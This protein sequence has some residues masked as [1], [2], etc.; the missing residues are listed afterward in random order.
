[1]HNISNGAFP[2]WLLSASAAALL[3]LV[4]G[5]TWFYHSQSRQYHQMA[6]AELMSIARLK[7]NQIA[8][9]RSERLGDANILSESP[10]LAAPV[11]HYLATSNEKNKQTLSRLFHSLQ[12]NYHYADILLVDPEGRVHLSMS[13]KLKMHE[14][15]RVALASALRD[16]KPEFTDLHT[17]QQRL[18][19]HISVVAPLFSRNGHNL[20]PLGAIILVSDASQF[21]YSLIQPWPT[22]SNS[23]ETYLVTRNGNDVLFLNEPRHQPGA[24]LKLRI[25]LSHTDVPAVMAVLGKQGVVMGKDYRG[26]EVMA[27][28]LPVTDTEWFMVA[29]ED[30]A[31][32]YADLRTR[33]IL[34]LLIFLAL[35][36]T[37][38]GIGLAAWQRRRKDYF[39]TLYR[40]EAKLCESVERHAITLQAIGDAVIVTDF[41]GTVELLN[42][43]ARELTGWSQSDASGR[44]LL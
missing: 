18:K 5:G 42:P 11:A 22:P 33:M 40:A 9:W 28:I 14:G 6:T 23:A 44:P 1:M 27:A 13:G 8:A 37:L 31:E 41:L 34:L 12:I 36:G 3:I 19:P 43:V 24:S 15:Y 29:K 26:I 39:Q 35:L 2:R 4:A 25:P 38:G 10:F 17:G 21:L 32:L 16:G 7:S 30:T 20:S